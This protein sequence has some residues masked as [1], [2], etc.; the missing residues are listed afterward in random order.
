MPALSKVTACTIGEHQ[1][2]FNA[3]FTPEKTHISL[4]LPSS[5]DCLS[6]CLEATL[7]FPSNSRACQM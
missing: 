2:L 7:P 6:S 4:G 5:F 1:F 3:Q